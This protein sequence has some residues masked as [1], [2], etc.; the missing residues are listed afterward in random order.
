MTPHT[1]I[2]FTMELLN[3]QE[4][5]NGYVK[6]NLQHTQFH[7]F[8]HVYRIVNS[9]ICLIIILNPECYTIILYL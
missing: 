7:T 1:I 6:V 4:S 9:Y 2:F 3:H 5:D 8:H